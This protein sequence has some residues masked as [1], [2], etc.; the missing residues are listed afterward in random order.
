MDIYLDESKNNGK[1]PPK[2]VSNKLKNWKN[3]KQKERP[4]LINELILLY[5]IFCQ[6]IKYDYRNLYLLHLNYN[7]LRMTLTNLKR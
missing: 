6:Q 4:V 7:Q 5:Y 3:I 2:K 1:I